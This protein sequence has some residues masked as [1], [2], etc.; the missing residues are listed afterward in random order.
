MPDGRGLSLCRNTLVTR[1]RPISAISATRK[2]IVED[3]EAN[4][5]PREQLIDPVTVSISATDVIRWDS[6][7]GVGNGLLTVSPE[8][9]QRIHDA[10]A[11]LVGLREAHETIRR[12][13]G[14]AHPE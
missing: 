4:E 13:T 7:P 11:A 8:A 14:I 10:Y 1:F 12:L 9:A 5:L 6:R 2:P 3:M